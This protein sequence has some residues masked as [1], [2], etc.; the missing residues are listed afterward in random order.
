MAHIKVNPADEDE[1][2]VAGIGAQPTVDQLDASAPVPETAM[3]EPPTPE[4]APLP[5]SPPAARAV[6]DRQPGASRSPKQVRRPESGDY[7]ET[8][9]ED[10]ETPG[11]P[12]AQRIVIVA[13]VVCIIGAI[14]YYL[15]AMR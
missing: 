8:T 11:M 2:I 15:V 3:D 1:V 13:A 5:A 9:L 4:A 6:P 10:L 12:L 14:V 7:H